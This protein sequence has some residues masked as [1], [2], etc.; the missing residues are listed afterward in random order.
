MG[1]LSAVSEERD[2]IL[3]TTQDHIL[4]N[5]SQEPSSDIIIAP[6]RVEMDANLS[7][8]VENVINTEELEDVQLN[9]N[10]EIN[11]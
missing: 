9:C 5:L 8:T 11:N 3:S 6:L 2:Q 1:D 7:P 4:G 10:E